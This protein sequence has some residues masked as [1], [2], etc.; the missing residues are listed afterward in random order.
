MYIQEHKNWP[1]FYFDPAKIA[2]LLEIC[3]IEQ[4]KLLSKMELLGLS[5]REDKVLATITSD[6]INSSEIEGYILNKK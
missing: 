1:E 3:H 2:S 6:V 5:E 4:G